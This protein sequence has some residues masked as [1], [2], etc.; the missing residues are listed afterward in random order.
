MRRIALSLAVLGAAALAACTGGGSVL[1][2]NNGS[3]IDHTIVT[4]QGTTNVAR[5]LPG[6]GL[7]LSAVAVSGSQNGI[8][9]NNTF[10][11]SAALTSGMFYTK[12]TLG[13]LSTVPCADVNIITPGPPPVTTAYLGDFGIYIAIDPTN[14]GNVEFIPPTII[15]VPG[16]LPVGTTVQVNYVYC[17]MVSATPGKI[18]GSGLSTK[19]TQTGPPGSILVQVVNPANPLQ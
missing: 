12:N 5:V 16:G 2:T 3:S 19:F 8:V 10:R 4:V 17:V 9:S 7:P 14:E 6:A 18:T 11:W 1:T 15:P 13:Q